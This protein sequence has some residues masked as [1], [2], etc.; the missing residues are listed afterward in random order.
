MPKTIED[1]VVN[2]KK[3][4]RIEK[5]N[6]NTINRLKNKN[7]PLKVFFLALDS[8]VW[9]YDSVYRLMEQSDKFDPLV[10]VCPI[11]NQ[12]KEYM[13]EKL[14]SCYSYF[15]LKGYNVLKAYNENDN[16]Y[17]EAS[18]L[19]PDIV[20]YT[21]PYRYLIDDRYYIHQFKDSLI[22]YVNYSYC[23]VPLQYSCAS[24][25]HQTV[26][27]YY[28]ECNDNLCQIK[29]YYPAKNCLVVGYPMFD[30]FVNNKSGIWPWKLGD[31]S[32][33]RIIW[34]PHHS[35]EGNTADIAFSTFLI[36]HEYMLEL[37]DKYRDKV[38]FAFKPHSILKPALYA[39][40]KWG[41][42][43]TDAYYARWE[44]G[45][46]T[47]CIEGEYETLFTTSDAMIHDCGSF[48]IEYLYVNKPVMILDDSHR[49]SQCNVAGIK[50]YECHYVGIREEDIKNFIENI[51]IN[52]N[53]LKIT[54]RVNYYKH[55]LLPPYGESVAH[56]IIND[57]LHN[58]SK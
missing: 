27:R 39:H 22:C 12:S 37:A 7:S 57:I 33:K 5:Q 29:E 15:S 58:I 14:N 16:E 32:L 55:Y 13:I 46:N 20:F 43:K 25:F 49:L 23:N 21:N 4:R 2:Y 24:E 35:I 31:K 36:F 17:L 50:A 28:V 45:Y 52:N 6:R 38:Q 8:S 54:D 48:I 3:K 42:E 19:A 44:N 18:S 11:V 26:W 34:A 41:K 47:I 30:Q 40:P 10:L 1:F 51:V 56:N 9:K 53:D